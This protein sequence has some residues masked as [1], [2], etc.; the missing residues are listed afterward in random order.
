MPL[1]VHAALEHAP[2]WPQAA[3][4]HPAC[5][6]MPATCAELDAASDA[7]LF[8]SPTQTVLNKFAINAWLSDT[9]EERQLILATVCGYVHQHQFVQ[10]VPGLTSVARWL[11]WIPE[12]DQPGA[13]DYLDIASMYKELSWQH[14]Y[15]ADE[16]ACALLS[17]LRLSPEHMTAHMRVHAAYT[18]RQ[19]H[20]YLE[21]LEGLQRELTPAQKQQH[22]AQWGWPGA[23]FDAGVARL[24][25]AVE[26][27]NADA[28]DT[29]IL[30]ARTSTLLREVAALAE[31]SGGSAAG[32]S[33]QG[34]RVGKTFVTPALV[35]GP[36]TCPEPAIEAVLADLADT[37]PP[38]GRRIMRIQH[39]AALLQRATAPPVP[40]DGRYS[41]VSVAEQ[42]AERLAGRLRV[43]EAAERE[44]AAK[45]AAEEQAAAVGL[46][47][48]AG[49][50]AVALAL[51]AAVGLLTVAVQ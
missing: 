32:P 48:A 12:T 43:R 45:K 31:G 51:P 6:T 29:L 36:E 40:V 4:V 11:R 5:P 19:A 39:L 2:A 24:K 9:Q 22:A 10:R 46:G 35:S 21:W 38:D 47:G 16:V 23:D 30:G 20:D 50:G 44:A 13:K 33:R 37:H 15:E 8:S 14:E 27:S 41:H 49:K 7:P 26:G 28:V 1:M 18:L 3:V 42:V 34:A 25:A 17:R